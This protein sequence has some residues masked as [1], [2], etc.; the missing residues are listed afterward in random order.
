[1]TSVPSGSSARPVSYQIAKVPCQC[2]QTPPGG[3]G[4]FHSIIKL[5]NVLDNQILDIDGGRLIRFHEGFYGW[6][7]V[8]SSSCAAKGTSITL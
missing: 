8:K 7:G 1:M 4:A 3:V 6:E 5:I 2:E